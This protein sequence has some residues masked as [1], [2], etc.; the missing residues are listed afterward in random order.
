MTIQ[1]LGGRDKFRPAWRQYFSDLDAIIYIVDSTETD[2]LDDAASTL[3]FLLDLDGPR[4]SP[5]SAPVLVFANK[6]DLEGALSAEEVSEG[7]KLGEIRHRKW[8]VVETCITENY[9]ISEGMNWL[10]VGVLVFFDDC[11]KL[12]MFHVQNALEIPDN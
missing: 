8:K 11:M 1:D 10:M 9:G 6:Q 2:R 3:E 5:S 7:L 12:M 4:D